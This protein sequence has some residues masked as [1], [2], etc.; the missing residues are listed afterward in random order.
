M[1]HQ[2]EENDDVIISRLNDSIPFS[3]RA[4]VKARVSKFS[5]RRI[6]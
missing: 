3:D 1:R 2:S 5:S 4:S 6:I